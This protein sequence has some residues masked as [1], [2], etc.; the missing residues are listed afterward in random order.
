MCLKLFVIGY[1]FWAPLATISNTLLW[2]ADSKEITI[3][4]MA[5]MRLVIGLSGGIPALILATCKYLI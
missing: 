1:A 4:Y 3:S 5:E 2:Y